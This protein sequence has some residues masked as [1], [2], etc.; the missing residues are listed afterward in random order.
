[1]VKVLL[2][3]DDATLAM[4]MEYTLKNE[5]FDVIVASTLNEAREHIENCEID[6]VLLDLMLPD[7]S[8]YELCKEVRKKSNMPII[9]LTASDEEANVVMGLD[10]GGDDYISKPVRIGELISRIKAVLRRYEKSSAYKSNKLYSGDITIEILSNRVMKN[11]VEI[12]LTSLEYKL[13][14][15]LIQNPK[16]VLSRSQILEKIWDVGGEFVD[17]NTLSVYI[18]RLR[19][20]IEDDPATPEYIITIRSVGYKWDKETRE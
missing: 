20:K 9:F 2:V 3:E 18:R 13:L 12:I 16:I 14:I 19:E 15:S 10:M 11:D 5:D 8:G 7:G 4:G 1:M 17:D 6:L